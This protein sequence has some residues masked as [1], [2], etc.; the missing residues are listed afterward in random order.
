MVI[1]QNIKRVEKLF[2]GGFFPGDKMDIV[3]QKHINFATLF[4]KAC[5]C[6]VADSVDQLIGKLFGR[7]IPVLQ[8]RM[9]LADFMCDRLDEMCFAKANLPVNKKRIVGLGRRFGHGQ[10]CRSGKYV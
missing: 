8:S 9:Q 2:L 1:V 6:P 10:A 5:R 7:H 3:D 4:S